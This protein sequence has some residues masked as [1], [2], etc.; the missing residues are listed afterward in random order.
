MTTI[1]TTCVESVLCATVNSVGVN[2]D[3]VDFV[4]GAVSI[5]SL[6]TV[7]PRSVANYTSLITLQNVAP[8]TI[9]FV[10]DVNVPVIYNNCRWLGL[11]G[12]VFIDGC[13]RFTV[14]TWGDSTAG[15][16]GNLT[17]VAR[18]SPGTI[19]G[20]TT[21]WCSISS[22]TRHSTALKTDG[23]LW[24][25]GYNGQGQVGDS[26]TITKSSPVQVAGGGSTW[27]FIGAKWNGQTAL[28]TDGTLWLWGQN[29]CGTLGDNSVINRSSPVTTV[30]GGTTWCA[31][32]SGFSQRIS[33]AIKT[34]GT[35]W[36]WG[37]NTQGRLGDGTVIPRSSPVT[38]SG[39]GTTW[40][41]VSAGGSH[42][43]AVKTDGTAWTWGLNSSGQLGNDNVITTSSPGTTVGGGTT[44]CG[45]IA[46]EAHTAAL[47]TDGTLWTWGF[48][49]NGQ[50]G[51]GTV[52]NCSSPVTTLGGG[53]A[54]C[55]ASVGRNHT[56]ALKTDGTVWTW[57]RNDFGHL[58]DGTLINRSSPVTPTGG[59]ANWCAV[60]AGAYHTAAIAQVRTN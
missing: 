36:M 49:Y 60:A 18:S 29:F 2:T 21:D 39:G 22:G 34:D 24:S 45:I 54:W 1:S 15:Q 44:W 52:V 37:Y 53:A 27:C 32:S 42:T 4:L 8:G 14:F 41:Q 17:A 13:D 7:H 9:M 20:T 50:L 23:S 12:R 31:V 35:L 10:E 40:C 33:A 59:G 58:G 11:D 19:A 28:K 16:L 56:A 46:S 25:W 43:V 3:V 51:N 6:C 57:G 26:T 30:G 38:T 55:A 47:K 48:N 5:N